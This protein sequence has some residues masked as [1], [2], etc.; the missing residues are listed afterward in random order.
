MHI[1]EPRKCKK[2]G[3]ACHCGYGSRPC[4]ECVN[5]ICTGCDCQEETSYIEKNTDLKKV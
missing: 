2:C 4:E 3:H 1:A 5:D